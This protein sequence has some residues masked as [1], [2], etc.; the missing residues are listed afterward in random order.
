MANR[1]ERKRERGR[2]REEVKIYLTEASTSS[3]PLSGHFG[4]KVR[5]GTAPLYIEATAAASLSLAL[6]LP[7][8]PHRVASRG[9]TGEAGH[10]KYSSDAGLNT[11]RDRTSICQ[12]ASILAIR[13]P[14]LE[15][16]MCARFRATHS[17]IH[18]CR[19]MQRR[20]FSP[21]VI[22]AIIWKDEIDFQRDGC[23]F[24]ERESDD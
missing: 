10:L 5:Q 23:R 22:L 13:I 1:N 4:S 24:R 9:L 2:K 8:P 11:K 14:A 18:I 3:S 6:F 21:L 12:P 17:H 16:C 20:D 15:T 19:Y 7:L